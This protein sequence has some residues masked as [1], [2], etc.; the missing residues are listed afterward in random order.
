M[1]CCILFVFFNNLYLHTLSNTNTQIYNTLKQRSLVDLLMWGRE[2]SD[3]HTL[4]QQIVKF[5][6]RADLY[7]RKN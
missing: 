3:T 1:T 5:I 6:H 4:K 7:N 2:Y